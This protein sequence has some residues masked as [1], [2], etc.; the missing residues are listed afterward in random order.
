MSKLPQSS[1]FDLDSSDDELIL[2]KPD[3]LKLAVD[4]EK[5]EPEIAL[6]VG[7]KTNRMK[8]LTDANLISP[9]G[10]SR[11]H[12]EF[13][14][15]CK[16]KRGNES[17]DLKHLME[18]YKEWAFQLH[19]GFAPAD[20]LLKCESL[21]SSGRVKNHLNDLR[22]DERDDYLV[23]FYFTNNNLIDIYVCYHF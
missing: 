3:E 14:K 8:P 5:K 17:G 22:S 15:F 1:L 13:P 7:Q 21:G 23:S 10:I 6:K 20:L 9:D 18:A 16:F 2:E 19:S 11:I 12:D 4:T